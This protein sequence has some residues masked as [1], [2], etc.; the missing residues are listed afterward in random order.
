M[1]DAAGEGMRRLQSTDE[2]S[3]N[4]SR[5]A[6]GGECGGKG[7][8]KGKGQRMPRTQSRNRHVPDGP[9]PR[10]WSPSPECRSRWTFDRSPTPGAARG[11]G[12]N[13]CPYCDEIVLFHA[14][15]RLAEVWQR[16]LDGWPEDPVFATSSVLLKTIGLD[17]HFDEVY[18]WVD[19][20]AN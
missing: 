3:N 8:R 18:R 17:L 4:A 15:K 1:D 7:R 13:S 10:T 5:Q 14:D 11:A 9:S 12:G 6:G 19:L 20:A 2:A 16:S